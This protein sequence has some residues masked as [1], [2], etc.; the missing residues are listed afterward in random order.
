MRCLSSLISLHDAGHLALVVADLRPDARMVGEAE[1]LQ[2]RGV[3]VALAVAL[4]RRVALRLA[5]VAPA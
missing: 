4:H 3:A 1:H 2:H 5:E